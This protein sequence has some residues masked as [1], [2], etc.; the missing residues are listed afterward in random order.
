[1]PADKKLSI[2]SL[3]KYKLGYQYDISCFGMAGYVLSYA[4]IIE[5]GKTP[6]RVQPGFYTKSRKR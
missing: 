2:S 4:G 6:Q 5:P 1:V 3:S